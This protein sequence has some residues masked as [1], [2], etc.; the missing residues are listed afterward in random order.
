[1]NLDEILKDSIEREQAA[2]DFYMDLAHKT[3][4]PG[5]REV[6]EQFAGEELAHKAKLLQVKSGKVKLSPDTK[7]EDLGIAAHQAKVEPQQGDLDYAQAL[8]LAMQRE[9]DSFRLYTQ[10]A[11]RADDPTARELFAG[12]AQEEAKH[13]LRFEIEYD[14]AILSEN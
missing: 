7:V 6:F 2:H 1:M 4:R 9:K 8:S 3:K 11:A 12:L 5:M 10:L 13:K 14:E